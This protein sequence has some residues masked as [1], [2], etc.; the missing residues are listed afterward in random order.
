M[1]VY[2]NILKSSLRGAPQGRERSEAKPPRRGRSND[3]LIKIIDRD[4]YDAV[5]CCDL[6]LVAS[7]TATLEVAMF[8][9]PMVVVYKVSFLTW[10]IARMLIRIPYIGLVNVVAEKKIIPE[11]IQFGA[12]PEKIAAECA[13]ILN[14]P[15]RIA[16]IQS[17]LGEV[18][19]KL[20]PPGASSNAAKEI[21]RFL[22][23]HNAN[24]GFV[25]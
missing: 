12:R 11:F 9:K 1:D 2:E 24:P 19:K 10:L 4:R 16:L 7:G 14:S 6:A 17:Q 23:S 8:E 13:A 20:G 5:N 21:L 18:K 3:G 15:A 22:N 25:G